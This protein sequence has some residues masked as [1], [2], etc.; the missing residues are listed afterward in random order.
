MEKSP[1]KILI[2]KYL[3]LIRYYLRSFHRRTAYTPLIFLIISIT[4]VG[5]ILMPSLRQ[6][7]REAA[8]LSTQVPARQVFG[9]VS[10]QV[11][12]P[13]EPVSIKPISGAIIEIGG[14]HTI[15]NTD[16]TYELM[17]HSRTGNRLPI[18][19]RHG[20]REEI[21]RVNLPEG[22]DKV[23]KDFIFR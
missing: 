5:V 6:R 13:N 21:D 19:F 7:L 22:G 12:I 1:V 17:F 20:D 10:E 23:R 4:L 2:K 15:S 3:L 11:I 9:T 16:G 8:Q 14:E 18:I